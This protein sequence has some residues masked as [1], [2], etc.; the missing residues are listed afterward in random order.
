V[1]ITV[2]FFIKGKPAKN[3]NNNIH[4]FYW[5]LMFLLHNAYIYAGGLTLDKKLK[6]RFNFLCVSLILVIF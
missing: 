4:K 6:N 5:F 2:L 3:V 1:C